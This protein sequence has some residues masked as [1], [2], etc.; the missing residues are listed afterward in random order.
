MSA[1]S[2]RPHASGEAPEAASAIRFDEAL[3]EV[4]PAGVYVCDADGRI[5]RWNAKAQELWGCAPGRRGDAE[6]FCGAAKLFWPDGR[7]VAPEATPMVHVLQTGEPASDCEFIVEQPGGNRIWVIAN[8]NAIRDAAGKIIGAVN[9]F[10]DISARKQAENRLRQSEE[11]LRAIVEATPECIKVVDPEGRLV[12]MNAAG[13]QMIEADNFAGVENRDIYT[14]IAPEHRQKWIHVHRDICAG[15]RKT[16]E[17]DIIGLR[18]TRRRMQSHAVPLKLPEG[19][20]GQLAVTRDITWERHREDMLRDSA[21]RSRSLVDEL[22]HRVKNTLATVRSLIHLSFA[23]GCSPD[24]VQKFQDRIQGL[25]I[26]HDLLTEGDWQG[27]GL[28]PLMDRELLPFTDDG[29]ARIALHGPD[30]F[31]APKTALSLT[32]ALH[33]LTTNAVKYGALS[34]P[35]GGLDICWTVSSADAGGRTLTIHWHEENGPPVQRPVRAGFGLRML[36]RG[37]PKDIGASVSLDFAP[38]GLNATIVIPLPP[39]RADRDHFG[40]DLEPRR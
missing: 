8:V 26:A 22:N 6:R 20:T 37:L 36:E 27:I 9:C 34:S 16:I 2:V 40:I 29:N 12:Q 17:F 35:A 23:Q 30:C 19:R 21:A 10:Q 13:L 24:A 39:M 3:F 28:R 15:N 7:P 33:E 18:G 31:L 1:K 14:V 25:S 38:P 4:V 32:I 11:H 5:L